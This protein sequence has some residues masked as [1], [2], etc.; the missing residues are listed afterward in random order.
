MFMY[1]IVKTLITACIIVGV[2]EL[3]K[4]SVFAS[5]FLLSL[6]LTSLLAFIWIYIESNDSAKIINMS[7]AVFWLV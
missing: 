1:F 3:A 6:P 4:R 7:Y 2:S 5:A